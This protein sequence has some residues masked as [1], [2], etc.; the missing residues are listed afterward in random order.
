MRIIEIT[1]RIAT[2]TDIDS[3]TANDLMDAH[4]CG[5]L[6][7][8]VFADGVRV[9]YG[10]EFTTDIDDEIV[11]LVNADMSTDL[12]D[13][14]IDKYTRLCDDISRKYSVFADIHDIN[15]CYAVVRSNGECNIVNGT[16][17]DDTMGR[18]VTIEENGMCEIITTIDEQDVIVVCRLNIDYWKCKM[19]TSP[20]MFKNGMFWKDDHLFTNLTADDIQYVKENSSY[21]WKKFE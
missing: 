4:D 1:N 3:T 5:L 18:V 2:I 9:F 19:E 14:M 13:E 6:S 20:E 8:D 7:S 12:T 21:I 10:S 15:L 16:L 17:A 11:F